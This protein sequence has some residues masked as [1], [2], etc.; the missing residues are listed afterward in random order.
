MLEKK[1]LIYMD[2]F[3]GILIFLVVFAHF[4]YG[5]FNC[6]DIVK[7]IVT[8]I[9]LFH[10]PL[11]MFVSGYLSSKSP[12]K[13]SFYKL[14]LYY[15]VFNT[16]MMIYLVTFN[17]Y[18]PSFINSYNS[19]WYLI[20]LILM[21]LSV[22]Y[23]D[24]VK[25]IIPISIVIS[26]LCG[27]YSWNITAISKTL[28]LYPFFLIGYKMDKDK[29]MEF[30]SS[31][32]FKHYILGIVLFVVTLLIGYFVVTNVSFT[33]GMLTLGKYSS[34]KGI[35]NRA[36]MLGFSILTLITCLYIIPNKK[37]PFISKWGRNSLYIYVTHRFFTLIFLRLFP[38]STWSYEVVLYGLLATILT[39]LIFSSEFVKKI[40]DAVFDK[41]LKYLKQS[42]EKGV[43][44]LLVIF[45]VLM[46][47]MKVVTKIM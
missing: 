39:M 13:D 19:Y 31:R 14:L 12:S 16:L 15:G 47:V 30:I 11:F 4:F 24:K 7:D 21:R 37:V 20:T 29:F 44:V 33:K 34:V 17:G 27:F 46:I 5:Y 6:G 2:N 9:Y 8:I 26:L 3:K 28:V 38:T 40:F 22:K 10:M 43:F 41:I 1:R 45:M 25:F 23:I 18:N 32:K 36:I 35:I 42:K